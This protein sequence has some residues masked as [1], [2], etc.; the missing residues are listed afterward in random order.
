MRDG[1]LWVLA[2]KSAMW[3]LICI[4][5][6]SQRRGQR[7][8]DRKEWLIRGIMFPMLILLTQKQALK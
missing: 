5:K 7:G 2:V 6:V 3:G 1:F 8:M 4:S